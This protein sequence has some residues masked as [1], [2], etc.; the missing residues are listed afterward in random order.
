MLAATLSI[1]NK[2]IEDLLNITFVM[3]FVMPFRFRASY[4]LASMSNKLDFLVVFAICLVSDGIPTFNLLLHLKAFW[5]HR[6]TTFVSHRVVT[7]AASLM[8]LWS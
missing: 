8:L 1:W 5:I 6:Y 2:Y 4:F 3:I 7:I